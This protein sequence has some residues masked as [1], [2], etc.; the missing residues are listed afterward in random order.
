MKKSKKTN[1]SKTLRTVI[2]II[3]ALTATYTFLPNY[4]QKGLIYLNPNIDDYKIFDNREVS[5][6]DPVPW[7]LAEKY[8]QLQLTTTTRD[9]L[10]KYQSVA[11]LVI[12]HDSILYEGYW[13]GYTQTTLSNSFSMAKSV[14]SLLIGCAI[15]DGF[16]TSLDEKV[17][18]YLP[19]LKG[20][21][22][23][24]LTIRHLL[25]MSSA[26]S[27]D[28]SYRSPFSITTRAYYGRSLHNTIKEVEIIQNP[29]I[30]W[31]YRSGDTQLL[32][33][34]LSKAT[35][36]TLAEYASQK[37][38]QPLGAEKPA[39]WS[40]DKRKGI[41]KAYCCFNSN[42]RDFARIGNLVLNQGQFANKRIV[43]ED[44]IE[45]ITTPVKYLTNEDAEMVDYYG[46]HWWIMNY[47]GQKIPYARGILGQYI[48]VV[49]RHDAIVV[50]LGHKRS[51][52]Y[53]N[54]HPKDAFTWLKAGLEIIKQNR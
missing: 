3:V 1:K 42:A 6:G 13:D 37:L 54:H 20:P 24:D 52:S 12:Q 47:E 22:S 16:V 32:E 17:K 31:K 2:I 14:V 51:S 23:E 50:R 26:S 40:L 46:L 34:I 21:H 25:S 15:E 11:F 4:L 49:P 9:S 30:V 18:N 41:E 8:G 27:W 38:W 48:Y 36:K 10:E 7:P 39:L 53:Q 43:S 29:G 33:R 28:E 45:K 44:Y 35:G 19:W 5:N